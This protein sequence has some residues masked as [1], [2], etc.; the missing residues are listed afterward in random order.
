MTSFLQFVSTFAILAAG[1]APAADPAAQLGTPVMGY[2]PDASVKSIRPVSGFPGA[3]ILG[4]PVDLNTAAEWSGVSPRQDFAILKDAR[5]GKIRI[6]SLP[7]FTSRILTSAF[8]RPTSISFSPSGS[9]IALY[10]RDR[11][12]LR[13]FTHLPQNPAPG[14]QVY[15]AGLNTGLLSAAVS[16]DGELALLLAGSTESA[17]LWLSRSGGPP[18]RLGGLPSIAAMSFQAGTDR[19]VLA[20]GDGSVYL[21]ENLSSGQDLRLLSSADDRMTDPVA[22]GFSSGGTRA[23]VATRRGTIAAFEVSDGAAVFSSCGCRPSSLSPLNSRM[24]RLNEI[25]EGP[26]M[27]LDTTDPQLRVWFVP[28]VPPAVEP[29]RSAQ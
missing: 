23:I 21:L 14:Y 5:D 25:S 18:V 20:A 3:A 27:L 2:V 11:P 7:D 8:D 13:M 22:A 17:T 28:A 19:A 16:D 10:R 4:N 26:L 24:L 29:E 1:C 12:A 6:V 15:L 9:A